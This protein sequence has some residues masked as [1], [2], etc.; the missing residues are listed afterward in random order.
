[1]DI[2]KWTDEEEKFL[3]SLLTS[4]KCYTNEEIQDELGRKRGSLQFKIAQLLKNNII[5]KRRFLKNKVEKNDHDVILVINDL[6][7]PFHDQVCIGLIYKLIDDLSPDRIMINGDMLDF[8]SLSLF[9][10]NPYREQSL[11]DEIDMAVEI[12]ENFRMICPLAEIDFI[13]GN[14][15]ARLRKYLN[16]HSEI[17]SLRS[18]KLENLLHLKELNIKC[19]KAKMEQRDNFVNIDD[20]LLVGHF[21]KVSKNSAYTAKALLDQYN[22]SLI[23]GHVHRGGVHLKRTIKEDFFAIENYCLC[24]LDGVEYMKHPNWQQGFTVLYIDKNS[25]DI[26]YNTVE[27]RNKSFHFNGKLYE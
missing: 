24:N 9:D 16:N 8:Y 12:L 23:Q 6:H 17:S 25:N 10:K 13:E 18:L 14:H 19:I 1:M 4:S 26:H 5:E 27:I 11:Q 3:I 20:K 2:K 7:V 15:E 21:N 22:M